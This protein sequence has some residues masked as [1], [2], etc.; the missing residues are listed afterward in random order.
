[1][2]H[3]FKAKVV[4]WKKEKRWTEF[5][6]IAKPIDPEIFKYTKYVLISE[7]M[8]HRSSKK[9]LELKVGD[10]IEIEIISYAYRMFEYEPKP[11]G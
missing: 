1:M 2:D 7:E 3:T 5:H 11:E 4:E 9:D 6:G 8:L 10:I